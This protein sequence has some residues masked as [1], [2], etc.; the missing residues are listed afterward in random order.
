VTLFRSLGYQHCT[1]HVGG[2]G[3]IESKVS[4]GAGGTMTGGNMRKVFSSSS[5]WSASSIH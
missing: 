3:D 5:A 2:R 1:D 4:L